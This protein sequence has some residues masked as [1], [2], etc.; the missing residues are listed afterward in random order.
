M[1]RLGIVSGAAKE[2]RR[3]GR[4]GRVLVTGMAGL[5]ALLLGL[6]LVIAYIR[7]PPEEHGYQSA[8]L[9]RAEPQYVD[10]PVAHFEYLKLGHG[11]PVVLVPGGGLWLLSYRDT[12]PTLAQASTIYAVD[13]PGQGYTVVKQSDFQYDLDAMANALAVF[14]DAVGVQRASLVG[15]S[16]GG[17]WV[18][19]FA[20]R[21]PERVDR[22]VLIDAPVLDLPSSWD[23][24]PLEF[25]VL[26]KLMRRSDVERV[27]RKTFAHQ[28]RVTADVVD[29]D[30]AAL[31]R[32]DNREALWQSQRRIDHA[33]TQAALDRVRAP[34]LVLWGSED[35][36]DSASQAAEVG[37]RIRGAT[38]RVL[39]GCGHAAHEDCPGLANV[40]LVRFLRD[41][42][43]SRRLCLR[44]RT[45]PGLLPRPVG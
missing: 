15:H 1:N 20:D 43:E 6:T 7:Q 38:V 39:D 17:T 11:E 45:Q 14:L 33:R 41:R 29:E 40:E 18:L 16:W 35:R 8:Y 12:T 4:R 13:L 9:A 19:V 3:S 36:F 37:R 28:D 27:L 34:T 2:N 23:W 5:V 42:L 24:R 22:L 44:G 25:P 10:T 30:W 32:A 21:C 31:S 26:G